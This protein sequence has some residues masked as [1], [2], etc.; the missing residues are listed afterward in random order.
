MSGELKP[1]EPGTYFGELSVGGDWRWEG[2]GLP[3][4]DWVQ[5]VSVPETQTKGTIHKGHIL[6]CNSADAAYQTDY[7]AKAGLAAWMFY[8]YPRNDLMVKYN[9]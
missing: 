1:A 5:I 9:I 3:D 8:V 6:C 7:S 2:T 4:D